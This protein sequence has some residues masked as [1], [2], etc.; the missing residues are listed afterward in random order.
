MSGWI[1]IKNTKS[2]IIIRP[3]QLFINLINIIEFV[4]FIYTMPGFLLVKLHF[5]F[6][7]KYILPMTSIECWLVIKL[8]EYGFPIGYIPIYINP[9]K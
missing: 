2:F 7:E 1:K 6:L 5:L 8:F 3:L 4:N 9:E